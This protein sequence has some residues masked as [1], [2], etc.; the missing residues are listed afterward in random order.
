MPLFA[1]MYDYSEILLL[2]PYLKKSG[3][4]ETILE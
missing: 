3:I 2:I 4:N 1:G